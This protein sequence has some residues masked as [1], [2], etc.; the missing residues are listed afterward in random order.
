M[1]SSPTGFSVCSRW[2]QTSETRRLNLQLDY[3]EITAKT[4]KVWS[5]Y[6]IKILSLTVHECGLLLIRYRR[7]FIIL[8]RVFISESRC[9]DEHWRQYKWIIER[10]VDRS[11][12]TIWRDRVIDNHNRVN[13]NTYISGKT[14]SKK[15]KERRQIGN[16]EKVLTDSRLDHFEV[17]LRKTQ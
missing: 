14:I 13:I 15:S 8:D 10:R 1:T 6:A 11:I 4:L 12:S 17:V 16:N 9:R 5:Q 3:C 7:L 2:H